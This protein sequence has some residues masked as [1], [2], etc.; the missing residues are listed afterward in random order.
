MLYLQGP[1]FDMR[2][3][4]HKVNFSSD[5]K[6]VMQTLVLDTNAKLIVNG[7]LTKFGKQSLISQTKLCHIMQCHT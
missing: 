6:T 2:K 4:R 7:F 1:Q 3:L 5:N